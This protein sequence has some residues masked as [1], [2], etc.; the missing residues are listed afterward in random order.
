M[1]EFAEFP[2]KADDEIHFFFIGMSEVRRLENI[3]YG[4]LGKDE[5]QCI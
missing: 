2:M 3:T 5:T 1:R 4:F